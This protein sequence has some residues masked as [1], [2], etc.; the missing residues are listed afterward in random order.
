MRIAVLR[1]TAPGEARVAL[2]P[3][4]VQRLA[5]AGHQ[6]SIESGAGL[7]AGFTD[8]EYE[9]SAARMHASR[10]EA[11]TGAELVAGPPA[12]PGGDQRGSGGRHPGLDA[13]GGPGRRDRAGARG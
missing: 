5:K 10:A 6:I 11:L 9:K 4:V 3:D 12:H 8:A 7:P 1:E 2:V 13:R